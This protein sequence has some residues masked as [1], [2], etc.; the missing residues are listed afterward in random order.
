[1]GCCYGNTKTFEQWETA[2]LNLEDEIIQLSGFQ[3]NEYERE[4]KII[5]LKGEQFKV[6]TFNFDRNDKS[7]E[8]LVLTHGNMAQAI[9]Y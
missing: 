4:F 1:M 9:S 8:T 2:Q 6:R 5:K 3:T 7:K